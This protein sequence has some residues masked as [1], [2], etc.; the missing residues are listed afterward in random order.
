MTAENASTVRWKVGGKIES[1]EEGE[2]HD[3]KG[4][5]GR[6]VSID[7][8]RIWWSAEDAEQVHERCVLIRKIAKCRIRSFR[9]AAQQ[10][11][12]ITKLYAVLERG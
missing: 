6:H 5:L 2:S 10:G 9:V 3:Y 4:D 7:R 1:D 12:R 8:L 11:E